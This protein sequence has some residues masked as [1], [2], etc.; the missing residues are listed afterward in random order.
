M[1]IALPMLLHP[2]VVTSFILSTPSPLCIHHFFLAHHHHN[3]HILHRS[4]AILKIKSISQVHIADVIDAGRILLV[5]GKPARLNM[6]VHSRNSTTTLCLT[7]FACRRLSI[8]PS[9]SKTA[10]LLQL[11]ASP[12]IRIN[13]LLRSAAR[14]GMCNLH[15]RGCKTVGLLMT[16]LRFLLLQ[17]PTSI[18]LIVRALPAPSATISCRL[19]HSSKSWQSSLW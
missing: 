13:L 4:S 19:L 17:R 15:P 5:G 3:D 8:Q 16:K 12:Q 10:L 18:F 7:T 1:H 2:Q 6:Y 11:Q 9:T 14:A